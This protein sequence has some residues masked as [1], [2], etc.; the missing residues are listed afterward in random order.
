MTPV[1]KESFYVYGAIEGKFRKYFDWNGSLRYVPLGYRQHDLDAAAAATL[2]VY[3]GDHP[4]SLT[5]RFGYT[6]H[7]PSYWS[8]T[9]SSN[10]F[11]WNNAFRKENET[12][13]EVKLTAPT[14][15]AEAAFYQSVLGNRVYYGTDAMP[16]QARGAV[17]VTGVYAKIGRAH[18]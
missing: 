10:H 11:I 16:R 9:F 17:S 2:S 1:K 12:R 4:V 14:V 8:Q 3:F 7:E 18:V 15:N 5:G 6:L 13:F